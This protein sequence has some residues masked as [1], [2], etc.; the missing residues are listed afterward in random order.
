[1]KQS[2][3]LLAGTTLTLLALTAVTGLM[4]DGE[5][6]WS[7]HFLLGLMACIFTCFVHV[8]FFVYFIVQE[9][10]VAQAVQQGDIDAASVTAV[11]ALKSRALRLAMI[12]IAS[13]IV[14]GG[15]GAAIGIL[16][17]AEVHL[18]ASLAAVSAN[19]VVFFLQL[20]LLD[21]YAGFFRSAFRE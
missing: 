19:G 6:G 2:Y 14:T 13:I 1:M 11:Q 3:W 20:T 10:I 7:R 4:V 15:L 17:P 8:I 9:K 21:E 5:T 18:I 16:V 12:G